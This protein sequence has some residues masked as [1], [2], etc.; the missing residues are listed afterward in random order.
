MDTTADCNTL[1]DVVSQHFNKNFGL[2]Y[3]SRQEITSNTSF[4]LLQYQND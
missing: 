2:R 1:I 3:V 4:P